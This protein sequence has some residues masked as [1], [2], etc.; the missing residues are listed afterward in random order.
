MSADPFAILGIEADSSP[1]QI[2]LAWKKKAAQLHP[3]AGGTHDEMVVLNNALEQALS[4]VSQH[5]SDSSQAQPSHYVRQKRRGFISRDTSCFTIDALPVDAWNL[6]QLSAAHC[7][8]IMDEEEPYLLEFM[9][10]DAPLIGL[11]ALMCRCEIVPEAGASTVHVALFGEN[12]SIGDV[13]S[14]RDFL[15]EAI[16]DL[17]DSEN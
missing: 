7:G 5:V 15:V 2:R 10:S 13:E 3:D 9:L 8:P 11:R 14:V 4:S 17:S 12:G 6:L 16:N 1:A